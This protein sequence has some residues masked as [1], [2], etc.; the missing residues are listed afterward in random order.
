MS[1]LEDR[2]SEYIRQGYVTSGGLLRHPPYFVQ[3]LRWPYEQ[4]TNND[5]CR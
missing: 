5:L 2:V 4:H 1:K 3:A